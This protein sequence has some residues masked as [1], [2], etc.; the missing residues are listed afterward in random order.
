MFTRPEAR[1]QKKKRASGV[2]G[3]PKIRL[4]ER[5]KP[6]RTIFSP[7]LHPFLPPFFADSLSAL[8]KPPSSLNPSRGFAYTHTIPT[9]P[10]SG[11][12]PVCHIC[13]YSLTYPCLSCPAV[14]VLVHE[15]FTACRPY[16]YKY[17]ILHQTSNLIPMR[18]PLISLP[19]P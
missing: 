13:C 7:P 5:E 12:V 10:C 1:T 14:T 2:E 6:S 9:A 8:N 4:R 17:P 3:E 15:S 18:P 11:T 19:I 16:L